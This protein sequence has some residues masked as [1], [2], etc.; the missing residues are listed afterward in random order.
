MRHYILGGLAL[1]IK[2]EEFKKSIKNKKVAV[3]GIGVSN[4]PLISYLARL[5]VDVT[6]FDKSDKEKLQPVL[7]KLKDFNIKYSFLFF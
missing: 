1:N 5:G 6:A 2:L 3:L 4:T 7:D